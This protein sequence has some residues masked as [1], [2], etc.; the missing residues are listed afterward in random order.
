MAEIPV[1]VEGPTRAEKQ[2]IKC[3]EVLPL[4]SFS[5]RLS[6]PDG[7]QPYCKECSKAAQKA[8]YARQKKKK[9]YA[10]K[11]LANGPTLHVYITEGV[12]EFTALAQRRGVS[13]SELA[14]EA[15]AAFLIL[16]EG[17]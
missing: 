9:Q 17:K 15:V 12:E 11:K 1:V 7:K 4:A 8:W 14:N 16:N 6:A 10:Q 2:C 13:R 5:V 3:E